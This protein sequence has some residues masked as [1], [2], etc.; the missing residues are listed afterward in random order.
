MHTMF[1]PGLES[2]GLKLI[3]NIQEKFSGILQL[4]EPALHVLKSSLSTS[5]AG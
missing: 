2:E 5:G 4:N 3:R 1:V